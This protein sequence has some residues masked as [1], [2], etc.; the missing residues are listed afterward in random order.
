MSTMLND[1]GVTFADG[2]VQPSAAVQIL[3]APTPT[4]AANA[5][6]IPSVP[7]SL[8]FRSTTLSSGVT[9]VVGG[10]PSALTIPSTATL[11]TVNAVQSSIVVLVMNNAGTLE[12][13][14]VNL[15]GGNDLSETGL[16]STTAISAAAT[17]ANVIY[18]N[19][20]R[21]N[22][23]YRVIARIDSTQSTAGTWATAPTLV[24]G[25]GGQALTAMSSLGYGQTWQN[26]T[27]S[28][29]LGT[30]YY[31][32]KGKPIQVAINMG[33]TTASSNLIVYVAG[34]G[35]SNITAASSGISA[36]TLVFTVGVGQSYSAT[37]NAGSLIIWF[38]M[39]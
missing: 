37:N 33:V 24:Q 39:S 20:A 4:I 23:A 36:Q 7:L 5:L 16:I 1:S 6:T 9:T 21:T 11:G 27:G 29:A 17:V 18:S 8:S 10:S 13:A 34:F 26:V 30:T 25:V 14:V 38:E 2:T 15:A 28:R 19:T 35:I 22:L 12:Y 32:T 3:T 31:N